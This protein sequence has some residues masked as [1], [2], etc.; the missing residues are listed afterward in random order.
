[1]PSVGDILEGK[2]RLV[3]LIGQG[4]MGSIFEAEHEKLGKRVAIKV[5]H[6]DLS[7]DESAVRRFEREPRAAAAVGH[8]AIVDVG[9][10]AGSALHAAL[11]DDLLDPLLLPPGGGCSAVEVGARTSRGL[12]QRPGVYETEV[13]CV[14]ARLPEPRE[15]MAPS[16][17]APALTG[18]DPQAGHRE[19]LGWLLALAAL[20]L[21]AGERALAAT[22]GRAAAARRR[23]RA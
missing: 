21:L 8:R 14:V 13:G 2:Y 4:G 7:L 9:G 18:S 16:A 12:I 11:W 23:G 20:G 5:L 19:P 17:A 22:S 15:E 6:S 1:M 10:L 3:R